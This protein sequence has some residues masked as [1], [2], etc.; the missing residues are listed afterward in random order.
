MAIHSF[1][2]SYIRPRN[3][4]KEQGNRR[5]IIKSSSTSALDGL[6]GVAAVIVVNFHILFS[7]TKF[8][9][10]GY[11]LDEENTWFFQLPFVRLVHAGHAMVVVFFVVGG[12]V[13]SIKPLA[14]VNS[15]QMDRFYG[16]LVSSIFRRGF[17]LYIPAIVA[18]FISM[19]TLYAGLWEHSRQYITKDKKYIYYADN[20]IYPA[21]LFTEQILHW[22]E[23]TKLLTNVFTYYNKGFSFP[24]YP[25]YDP[26]L[27]TIPVE[28]R[29]SLT[30]FLTLFALSR[31]KSCARIAFMLLLNLFC[32]SW[33]RWELVC[34][35]SGSL[36]CE[37]DI[38]TGILSLPKPANYEI[39]PKVPQDTNT[40]DTPNLPLFTTTT[41]T[42]SAPTNT[43]LSPIKRTITFLLFTLSL[44]LL[45]APPLKISQTPGYTS[46]SPLIPSTY[47]DPK[48]FPHT[49]GALLLLY[50]TLRSST[51]T[52]VLNHPLPQYLGKIS[53][54]LYIVHGPIIHIIGYTFTPAAWKYVTGME[55]AW[56]W[57]AGLVMGSAVVGVTASVVA[58]WFWRVVE[59]GSVE[60]ARRVE[61]W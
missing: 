59:R 3:D 26:H 57:G 12:Y 56:R 32:I 15:G 33:D 23:Q 13:L 51:L 38:R 34:F 18:T 61:G 16:S 20:H 46:L 54:S 27:W 35:L 58:D 24:Y 42:T 45:S 29:S 8:H 2:P 47:S 40:E 10:F 60:W 28:Y 22:L 31:C 6:R 11:G 19:V 25:Q 21:K 37:I 39:E 14:L 41:T 50:C 36:L 53:F 49:L 4:E 17:R 1:I 52:T 5:G 7:Y 55:D 43:R 44:Y 9:D 48:R 30:L